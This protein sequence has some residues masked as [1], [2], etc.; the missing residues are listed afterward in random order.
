[1]N[2]LSTPADSVV[3]EFVVEFWLNHGFM[4]LKLNSVC[5]QDN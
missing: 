1:M 5:T 4:V 3:H 2:F